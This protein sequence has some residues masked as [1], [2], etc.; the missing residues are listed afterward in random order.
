MCERRD[1]WLTNC[2]IHCFGD[3]YRSLLPLRVIESTTFDLTHFLQEYVTFIPKFLAATDRGDPALKS[4]FLP[5]YAKTVICRAEDDFKEAV[6]T[7]NAGDT[8]ASEPNSAIKAT[9]RNRVTFIMI[10]MCV[11]LCVKQVGSRSTS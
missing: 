8:S 11:C 1:L 5:L 7:P 2:F 4:F 6:L 3:W 9:R 10:V